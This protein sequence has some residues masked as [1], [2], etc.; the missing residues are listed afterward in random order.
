MEPVP[1]SLTIL[2]SDTSKLLCNVVAQ[3]LI[4]LGYQVHTADDVPTTLT[5]LAQ[6]EVHLLLL[7]ATLSQAD[8]FAVL[9]YLRGNQRGRFP[10]VLIMSAAMTEEDHRILRELG[11]EDFLSKPFLL[12]HLFDHVTAMERRLRHGA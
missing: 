9:Q 4:R 3:Y 8:D 11:A 7:D 1:A 10:S 6:E 12:S 5:V 2:V